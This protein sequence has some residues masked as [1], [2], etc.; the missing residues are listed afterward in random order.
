MKFSPWLLAFVLSLVVPAG[1][2]W[3]QTLV[4]GLEDKEVYANWVSFI[5]PSEGEFET[6]AEL[7]GEAIATDVSIQVDQPDYHELSIIRRE[8]PA[9]TE[10]SKL[11]QFIVRDTARG[12]SE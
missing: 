5:V 7:N 11:V 4:E 12:N 10:E 2:G 8:L 1:S 9:G 3:A 6:R